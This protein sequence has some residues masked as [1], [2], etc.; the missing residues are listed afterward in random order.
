VKEKKL[1]YL[2]A[3]VDEILRL[4]TCCHAI[5][6]LTPKEGCIIDNHFIRGNECMLHFHFHLQPIEFSHHIEQGKKEDERMGREGAKDWLLV[7]NR[8]P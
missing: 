4:P 5:V 1:E 7:G 6:R 3:Y 8:H 2:Q